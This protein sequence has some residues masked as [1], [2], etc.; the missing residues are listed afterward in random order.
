MAALPEEEPQAGIK[1]LEKTT[2]FQKRIKMYTFKNLEYIDLMPFFDEAKR[3]FIEKTREVL[4]ELPNVKSNLILE[5]QF[6][7]P[8]C[9][10]DTSEENKISESDQEK[11]KE[12]ISTVEENNNPENAE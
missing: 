7:R 12:P 8:C 2:A 10:G 4:L 3:L 1:V 6:M 5:A 9:G 11:E